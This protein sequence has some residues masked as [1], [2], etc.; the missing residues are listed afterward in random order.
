MNSEIVATADRGGME[1]CSKA[2]TGYIAQSV[3]CH[4]QKE[5]K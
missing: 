3:E 2:M 1:S 4:R 5:R